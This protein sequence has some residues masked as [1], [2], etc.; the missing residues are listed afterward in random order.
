MAV[1]Q[2]IPSTSEY[3]LNYDKVVDVLFVGFSRQR[4][5]STIDRLLN[6]HLT[7]WRDEDSGNVTVI[8]I[9]QFKALSFFT[10]RR[11]NTLFKQ[12]GVALPARNKLK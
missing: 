3:S 10:R 8:G 7:V 5:P 12:L 9:N 2:E 6:E 1:T 11:L 4:S